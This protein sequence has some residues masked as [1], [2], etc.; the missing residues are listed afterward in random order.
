MARYRRGD[1]IERRVTDALEASGSRWS[2]DLIA[3]RA[4]GVPGYRMTLAF[5]EVDGAR[6]AFVELD[7]EPTREGAEARGAALASDSAQLRSLLE[8]ELAG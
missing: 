5:L 4:T 2:V 8:A 3:K 7:P 1:Q 6:S